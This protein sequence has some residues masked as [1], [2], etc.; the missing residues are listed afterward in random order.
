MQ[1]VEIPAGFKQDAKGRLIPETHIKPIELERDDLTQA[2]IEDAKTLQAKMQAFK[3]QAFNDVTAFV[4][5]SAEQYDIKIG[6][7]KGNIT[8][9]SFDGKYK[10]VRQIQDS[11]RFDER[12]SAAKALID[13]CIQSWSEG[14]SDNIKILVNDAFQVDK[15]GKISVSRVLGLRRH[16]IEDARWQKAMQAISD[17]IIVTDSKNYIRFYE[18][19]SEGKYQAISLDFAN[20]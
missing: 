7:N 3:R 17:S 15:E 12:L 5:L 18:R 4:Q 8:L 9:L 19:D 13:E 11:I 14:S 6:G 2:L 20:I 1:H 10:V 16:A